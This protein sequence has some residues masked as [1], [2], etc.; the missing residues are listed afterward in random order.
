MSVNKT[1]P[2]IQTSLHW[3]APSQAP[4]VPGPLEFLESCSIR[5]AAV[6]KRSPSAEVGDIS[7]RDPLQTSTQL[8]ALDTSQEQPEKSCDEVRSK[9]SMLLDVH[10]I[11]VGNQDLPKPSLVIQDPLKLTS[12]VQPPIQENTGSGDVLWGKCHLNHQDRGNLDEE[13][14]CSP[15]WADVAVLVENIHLP[16]IVHSLDDFDQ[17]NH[18]IVIEAQETGVNKVKNMQENSGITKRPSPQVRKNK[19]KASSLITEAPAGKVQLKT[20]E[21]LLKGEE[22]I[23]SEDT[24]DR[25]SMDMAELKNNKPLSV[26]FGRTNQANGGGKTRTKRTR[27]NKSKKMPERKQLGLKLKEEER[28]NISNSKR[29]R[30]QPALGQDVF[31]VPR[32]CLGMHMLE[33][34]QVFYPLGRKRDKTAGPFPSWA[35]GTLNSTKDSKKSPAAKPWQGA[36]HEGKGPESARNQHSSTQAEESSASLSE[37]PPPGQVRLI[38]LHFPSSEKPQVKPIS[39]RPQALVSRRP[40]VAFP[41]HPVAS[42]TAQP[43]QTAAGN[44]SLMGPF[45]PARPVLENAN[46]PHWTIS[47]QPGLSQSALSKAACQETLPPASLKSKLVASAETKCRAPPQL[48][49]PFF[50]QDFSR[51]PIPWREPNVPEPVK[52]SPITEEQRPEREAMKRQAQ[53]E[54]ELAA[55]CTSLGKLQFFRQ[56]EADREVAQYYGYSR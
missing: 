14:E 7:R 6:L 24:R 3:Q 43:S 12:S 18:P 31:K 10:Q 45:K 38:P 27:E 29:K 4:Y 1:S 50:L 39:R 22:L 20:P 37:L 23:C 13:S 54:R 51:Q 41:V 55:K 17:C 34:V 9:L 5:S 30:R 8:L 26:A 19:H 52:S 35:R 15:G 40:A 42:N 49:N 32:T 36:P 33:S 25:T 47:K 21:G 56:R 11:L 28:P 53:Q 48:Q 44:T 2:E 16:Q 46:Q